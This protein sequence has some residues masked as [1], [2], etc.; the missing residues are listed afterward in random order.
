MQ[1]TRSRKTPTLRPRS[2]VSWV[3]CA[4]PFNICCIA[5]N[6]HASPSS[7]TK[8]ISHTLLTSTAPPSLPH[9]H[10][11]SADNDAV[12]GFEYCTK[13][14]SG[15]PLSNAVYEATYRSPSLAQLQLKIHVSAAPL[16][17]GGG[18]AKSGAGLLGAAGSLCMCAL[19]VASAPVR[20]FR[21]A[22]LDAGT[23][24]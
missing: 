5:A 9:K 11:G 8:C 20:P 23:S 4:A 18:G 12:V 17:R 3:V 21:L 7:S 22:R 19:W 13:M 2:R 16:Q 10:T 1:A 6:R 15:T 14:Q 24:T